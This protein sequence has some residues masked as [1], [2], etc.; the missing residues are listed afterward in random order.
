MNPAAPVTMKYIQEPNN[1]SWV[2]R[3][4]Q[5]ADHDTRR[6]VEAHGR[7]EACARGEHDR[8]RGDH[9]I[10]SAGDV[11]HLSRL[12]LHAHVFLPKSVMPCSPRGRSSASSLSLS[13]SGAAALQVLLVLPVPTTSRSS[14]M[15]GVMMLALVARI[16][17]ALGIDEH[18]FPPR[19]RRMRIISVMWASP[20][21]P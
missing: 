15:F 6:A 5:L 12:G 4:A 3:R 1:S 20:P 8:E 2:R 19:A 7:L 10:T 13:R 16:I 21:L 14:A 17:V 11:E 9:R 18:A